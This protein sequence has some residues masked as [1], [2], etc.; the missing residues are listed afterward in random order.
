MGGDQLPHGSHG[1]SDDSA[2]YFGQ[3]AP[4]EPVQPITFLSSRCHAGAIPGHLRRVPGYSLLSGSLV[5]RGSNRGS[6][7]RDARHRA[8]AEI[9][10]PGFCLVN[11]STELLTDCLHSHEGSVR[12]LHS[13]GR[14]EFVCSSAA[15]VTS[16]PAPLFPEVD[17]NGP[18]AAIRSLSARP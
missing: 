1:R 4:A 16:R 2:L 18:I 15:R 3:I 9:P 17:R 6:P 12:A 13:I 7:G 14:L 10:A 5:P 8:V 11:C